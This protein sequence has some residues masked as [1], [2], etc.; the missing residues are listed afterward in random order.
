[1][2]EGSE[3]P[4]A[5][6]LDQLGAYLVGRHRVFPLSLNAVGMVN[7]ELRAIERERERAHRQAIRER[8]PQLSP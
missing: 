2:A 4:L 8:Y 5:P 7:D 1:M 3:L 6:R